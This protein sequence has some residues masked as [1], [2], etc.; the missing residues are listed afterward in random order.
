MNHQTSP[1]LLILALL[2]LG[3]LLVAVVAG[4]VGLVVLATPAVSLLAVATALH[5]WPDL[6]LELTGPERAVEGDRIDLVV[7]ARSRIGVP[8][9]Q[10][11]LDLPP[12]LEP[13]DG[14][15]RAVVAVPPGRQVDVRFPVEATR[16]GVARPGRLQAVARDRFG[17]FSSSTTHA[18]PWRLRVHPADGNRR[19]VIAPRRLRTRVGAHLAPARGDGAEFAEVRPHRPGDPQ[20]AVNWRVSSRRGERWVTVRHPDRSGD[21]LLLLDSF[22]DLGPDGNRLVQRAVRA[23]MALTETGLAHHDRVGLLDV[24]RH[25][26]WFRPRLGRL[27]HARLFDALLDTQVDPGLRA[28]GLNRLPVHEVTEGSLIVVI[29]GL[30]DPDLASLPAALRAR[31]LEVVV[32]AVAP[33]AHLPAGADTDR[34]LSNRLWRLQQARRRQALEEHGVPVVTWAAGQPLEVPVAALARRQGGRA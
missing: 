11:A 29:T 10:L 16:W 22:T 17:L 18:S 23:A 6:E 3:G 9:L 30:L 32:L 20:R 7:T 26:R 8:W 27:H 28:P 15:S 2:G 5:R 33:E 1:R 13:A 4:R 12:D 24:G 25:V 14:I 34:D 19:S 21:L 31:G